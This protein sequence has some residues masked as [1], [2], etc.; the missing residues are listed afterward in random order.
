[1]VK[2]KGTLIH[3]DGLF[4]N[5]SFENNPKTTQRN[6]LIA[7]FNQLKNQDRSK[8][9]NYYGVSSEYIM[10]MDSLKLIDSQDFDLQYTWF[11][12]LLKNLENKKSFFGFY[13]RA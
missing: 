3:R 6:F 5:F 13:Y 1:M 7:F 9:E 8:L 2:Q 4:S 11:R 12:N 10:K